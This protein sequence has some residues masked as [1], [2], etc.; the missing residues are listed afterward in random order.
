MFP[1]WNA[2]YIFF[3]IILKFNESFMM[4][5]WNKKFRI[6]FTAGAIVTVLGYYVMQMPK[7]YS[8]KTTLLLGESSAEMSLPQGLASFAAA[9]DSKLDTYLQ[10]M[11]SS[12]FAERVAEQSGLMFRAELVNQN[13]PD[14]AK[15]LGAAQRLQNGLGYSRLGETNMVDV[16]FESTTPQLAADVVNA[17]GP[18]FFEYQQQRPYLYYPMNPK[19]V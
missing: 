15:R 9:G 12:Q 19:R 13:Q 1:Q 11:R 10:Y 16:T 17:V 6:I 7:V 4:L 8:A 3:F 18:V 14:S 5:I 2:S